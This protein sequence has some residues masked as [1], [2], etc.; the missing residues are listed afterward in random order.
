MIDIRRN[1]HGPRL[2]VGGRRV[3]HGVLGTVLALGALVAKRRRVAAVFIVYAASDYKDF[4][5]R[6]IDNH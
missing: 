5:F 2:Y 4:P 1:P 3:H 6:D